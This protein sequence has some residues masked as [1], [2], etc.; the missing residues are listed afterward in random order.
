VRKN[1]NCSAVYSIRPE[2]YFDPQELRSE[3]DSELVLICPQLVTTARYAMVASSVSPERC[4][5]TQAY[6]AQDKI[7]LTPMEA[8]GAT[9]PGT[10][11]TVMPWKGL[12][13][14]IAICLDAEFTDLWSLLGE[15]DLDL[16]LVPAKTDMVIGPLRH[17][18][19]NRRK[20]RYG[21]PI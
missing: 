14:A 11:V 10:V 15:L 9:L 7:S 12:R 19:A 13:V 18:N 6:P 3:R 16:V 1:H 5:I 4:D 2:L 8:G 20:I 21:G 17:L